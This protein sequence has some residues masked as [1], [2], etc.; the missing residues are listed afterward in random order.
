MSDP[1]LHSS[2]N[3]DSVELAAKMHIKL[4]GQEEVSLSGQLSMWNINLSPMFTKRQSRG[5]IWKSF[6]TCTKRRNDGT[7]NSDKRMDNKQCKKWT[8]RRNST[9]YDLARL[10]KIRECSRNEREKET[11]RLHIFESEPILLMPTIKLR[12]PQ[13]TINTRIHKT[14]ECKSAPLRLCNTCIWKNRRPKN[15]LKENCGERKR[16][17]NREKKYKKNQRLRPLKCWDFLLS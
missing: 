10:V 4:N 1:H 7:A 8:W 17:T 12:M 13:P 6:F 5:K 11:S 14:M 3:A 2:S 15:M 9:E 16:W